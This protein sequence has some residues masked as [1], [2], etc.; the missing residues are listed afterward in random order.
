VLLGS[1]AYANSLDGAFILDDF[2]AIVQNPDLRDPWSPSLLR[3]AWGES[4]LL[5][6]PLAALTFAINH[7]LHGLDA[8]GY[9][10]GNIAIHLL[11]GLALFGV[12]RR[13]QH[14]VVFAFACASLWI[15]HPL[16]S[17]VVNYISQRTESMMAL[18]YLLTI[19]CSVRAQAASRAWPWVAGAMAASALGT[20]S[21]QS[22][23]TVTAAVLLVDYT[24]FFDSLRSAIRRRW[25]FYLAVFAASF[26]P[27][28]AVLLI[29]PPSRAV[30]FASGPS[31]WV[32]LLNQSVM[33]THY[34][35][36][37]VWPHGLVSDYGYPVP[38]SLTDVLP[39]MVFVSG[40][41]VL[42]AAA[43]RYRP[44]LG[45]LG[46]WVFLTLG[47]T[48]SV[49]PIATEVGAE[50]RMYVPMAALVVLGVAPFAQL[51]KH[52]MRHGR[53][54]AGIVAAGC[55]LL[56]AGAAAALGARTAVRN[57]DYSSP[58][59][60]AEVTLE[61][62]PT[63]Y[64]HHGVG[65][66]LL[67]AG[68]R[69]EALAHLRQAIP[70]DPRAHFT[71]GRALFE[72]GQLHQAREQLET[73][74]RLQPPIVHATDGSY[75]RPHLLYAHAMIGRVL[76]T[77]G[78]LDAAAAEFRLVLQMDP[79]FSD[80]HLDLAE[81]LVAQSR[82]NDAVVH[83]RAY[84]ANGGA[85]PDAWVHL[86]A[87]LAL[88]NRP[89]EAMQVLRQA[90][91]RNPDAPNAHRSLAAMLLERND[92]AAAIAHA[93]RAVVLRPR[94]ALARD[95]LGVAFDMHGRRDLA[96]QQ[97]REALRLDPANELAREHLQHVQGR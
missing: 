68:R 89:D 58:L 9:H 61:H 75:T 54:P 90:L 44:K 79:S 85:K 63:A 88:A 37:V 31:P 39:Q 74:V 8:R 70:V 83:F 19:Y 42:S 5:G 84:L 77:E 38:Y 16:N 32:Y 2:V 15:L 69:D 20:L 96:I 93:E 65:E 52:L 30:G 3:S 29:S 53:L 55:V 23:I 35:R 73:F 36:L 60:L 57:R 46:A 87:A 67:F 81:V 26:L 56:W 27:G 47:V 6:R 97:F 66:E 76:L 17:E 82:Y 33:I 45:L 24:L 78:Q 41:V 95:L 86:G 28:M 91:E 1:L 50:R 22:M 4:P 92:V 62:W 13:V 51:S 71:L 14:S 64:S 80:A 49:A 25:R 94:D 10:V 12:I 59:R 7:A 40:L 34:L 21:K 48:S 72:G 43:L 11:C 18:F